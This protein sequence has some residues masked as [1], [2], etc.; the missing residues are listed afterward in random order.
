LEEKD[1]QGNGIQSNIAWFG[2]SGPVRSKGS[3]TEDKGKV[4]IIIMGWQK[5]PDGESQRK[6]GEP[7]E[8]L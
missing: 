5:E 8:R 6:K 3:S 4:D 2:S 1:Q 7:R